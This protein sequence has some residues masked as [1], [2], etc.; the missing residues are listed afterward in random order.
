MAELQH[1][2]TDCICV[3]PLCDLRNV[4][5]IVALRTNTI[6]DQFLHIPRDSTVLD[7]LRSGICK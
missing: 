4:T 1:R 2:H 6:F 5:D 3:G 7:V